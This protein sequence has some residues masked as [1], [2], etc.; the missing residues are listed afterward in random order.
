L[1]GLE[2]LLHQLGGDLG[3]VFR[4]V[5]DL[6]E[7]IEAGILVDAVDAGDQPRRALRIGVEVLVD[8]AGGNVDDV[9]G[10]P[11]VTLISGCGFQL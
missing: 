3:V 7:V 4:R 5:L 1:L 11:F 10:F 6:L 2:I 9:A 8:G